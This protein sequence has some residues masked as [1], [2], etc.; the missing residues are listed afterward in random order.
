VIEGWM[1]GVEEG[2]SGGSTTQAMTMI[3]NITKIC[4]HKEKKEGN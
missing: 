2:W 1:G 4:G 3:E